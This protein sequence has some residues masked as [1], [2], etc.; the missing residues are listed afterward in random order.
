MMA[1][2]LIS[3]LLIRSGDVR[4]ELMGDSDPAATITVTHSLVN[5]NNGTAQ[6]NDFVPMIGG[7]VVEWNSTIRFLPG[8]YTVSQYMLLPGYSVG[9]WGGDC[10]TDGRIVLQAAESAVCTVTYDDM[11]S[12]LVLRHSV[13]NDGGGGASYGDFDVY[14]NGKL[15]AWD[16]KQT[17]DAGLHQLAITALNGYKSSQWKGD[18]DIDGSIILAPGQVAECEIVSNDMSAELLLD[19]SV[20][21]VNPKVGDVIRFSIVVSNLGPDPATNVKVVDMVTDGLQYQRGSIYGP[22]KQIDD[23]PYINGLKWIINELP[24]GVPV[25]LEFEAVVL[26][27]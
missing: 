1:L 13:L 8:D 17:L 21:D 19:K 4:G 26:P 7:R 14:A 18:C 27:L 25:S 6:S 22:N 10:N 2:M 15:A 5:D 12:I 3:A 23:D 11:P 16:I 20:S 9:F 24:V